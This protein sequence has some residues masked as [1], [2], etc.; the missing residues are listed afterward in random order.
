MTRKYAREIDANLERAEESIQAADDLLQGEYFDIAA[1]R[2]YYAVFY[3]ATALLLFDEKKFNKHS[4]II[5]AIHRDFVK[6]G[7]LSKEMGKNLNWLFGL[8]NIGDYGVMV[9]VPKSD[10]E[11]AIAAARDFIKAAREIL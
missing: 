3:A 7:R 5:S 8:R 11:K 6:T 1:S 10:A 4:G 9:H 2:A